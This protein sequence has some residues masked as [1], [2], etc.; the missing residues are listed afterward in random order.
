MERDKTITSTPS[1][2]SHIKNNNGTW[3]IQTNS[4]HAENVAYLA[5]SFADKFGMGEFGRI[6]GLL[7]DKGKEQ[8]SFQ[9]HIKKESGYDPS[10]RV[11]GNYHHAYVGALI[12]KNLF[13]GVSDIISPQIAG[14]HRGLYDSDVFNSEMNNKT[15]PPEVSYVNHNIEFP[16][17]KLRSFKKEDF[18][19][20]YR[21]LFSCLVD[22][23]F[24]D[25]EKFMNE[26][27]AKLRGGKKTITE[28]I[29]LLKNYL[30]KLKLSAKDTDVN[31]IRAEVQ[32][33]C[34][35]T[36]NLP[37]GF[38]SLTVPTGG[39]KT[40]SSL[41]WAMRHAVFHQLDRVIIA[42]PYTSIIVQTASI[43]KSIFGE[44]NVLEHHS[45]FDPEEITDPITRRKLQLAAENWD[46]PIVITTNVQL[47]ESMFSNKPSDC[48]KL[49]NIVNSV[50]T[51][52]E[53]QTLPTNFLQPIVDSLKTYNKIFGVSILFTTAS[54]P[55]LSG[56]ISGCNESFIGIDNITELIPSDFSLHKRLRRVQLEINNSGKTYDEVAALLCRHKKVLCI[57]N[58]RKNAK[59]IFERLPKEGITIHL[60]RMMCP[61]HVNT[62]I[63]KLKEALKNDSNAVIRV[64]ATQLIEAGVD[65]DFPIV[66]R[67]ETGLDSV[68]QAAGRCNREGKLNIGK[69]Y[70]FSLSKEGPLPRGS[71]SDSN[72]ARLSLNSGSDWFA[73]ATMTEYFYQLYCRQDTFDIKDMK[74]YLYDPRELYFETAAQKFKLIE[75]TGV[76]IVVNY[77]NSLTLIEQLK[78]YGPSYQLMKKLSNYTVNIKRNDFNELKGMGAVDE[79]LEGVYVLT[80]KSQYDLNV[81]L[82]TDNHWL[83]EILTI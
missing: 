35:E 13:K 67:Q 81:G 21:V 83:D 36:S 38:Y 30:A 8:T 29:P 62:T 51:L 28:L 10:A 46:Y 18:H 82:R 56:I 20:L 64:V 48:R 3:E 4:E 14:H 75:D 43:L 70:V 47:F 55:V 60:S 7:H 74:Y 58:T 71:I 54:Q 33:R 12:A 2:I 45:N 49:H 37:Q 23:D 73:P 44:E 40:L 53:V 61:K 39:G 42:I 26:D 15:I 63:K 69:T 78:S 57:V 6:M 16:L 79:V 5:E 25:T 19:H 22:A 31:R 41:L 27:D 80:D 9:Q 24:I 32:L 59:E 50:L 65:I 34:S 77:E 72:A 76:S 17:D 66:Y 11:N 1:I 68:L 52:D